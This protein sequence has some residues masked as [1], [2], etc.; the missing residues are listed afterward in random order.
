V[1]HP[2]RVPH[3]V[4][5]TRWLGKRQLVGQE[6]EQVVVEKGQRLVRHFQTRQRILFRLGH[7]FEEAADLG[8][9]QLTRVAL[10]VE[11]HQPP[12]P[13]GVALAR[14]GPSEPGE[15]QLPKTCS[16]NRGGWA[17]KTIGV[18]E[19]VDICGLSWKEME[20]DPPH[21]AHL[22]RFR[23]KKKIGHKTRAG[24]ADA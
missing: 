5:Q 18:S 24:S 17:A 15:G 3:P 23:G 6:V 1:P 13:I 16:G 22:N 11:Q 9:V 4:E 21:S 12:R 2:Q 7:V 10:A 14:F 19:A 8:E 20:T